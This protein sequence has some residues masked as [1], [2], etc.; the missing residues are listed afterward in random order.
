MDQKGRTVIYI[1]PAG[2]THEA[3]VFAFNVLNPKL[4][5]LVYVD[6][7][8]PGDGITKV[9][10]IEHA[11]QK[12]E[13]N[14]ELPVYPL[15]AWKEYYEDHQVIP[16]DHPNFDHPFRAKELALNGQ[17]IPIER[18]IT[19]AFESSY[20]EMQSLSK[21]DTDELAALSG[22]GGLAAGGAVA[23]QDPVLTEKVESTEGLQAAI[24]GITGTETLPGGIGQKFTD[25]TTTIP[26]GAKV[27]MVDGSFKDPSEIKVGD[28]VLTDTGGKVVTF[29]PTTPAPIENAVVPEVVDTPQDGGDPPNCQPGQLC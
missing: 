25:V 27:A 22:S 4:L 11:D 3:L 24:E 1:D 19:Q 16:P 29:T 2:V 10:S 5:D 12:K 18:P 26:E 6:A 13:T 23:S 21:E 17:P 20:K 8:A 28:Q 14:P 7:K 15:N 9:F